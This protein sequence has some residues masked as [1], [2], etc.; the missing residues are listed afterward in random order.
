MIGQ[1]RLYLVAPSAFISHRIPTSMV[2]LAEVILPIHAYFKCNCRKEASQTNFAIF[3]A[4][5]SFSVE[6]RAVR[7]GGLSRL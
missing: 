7:Y 2:E 3:D 4:S 6:I 1:P 5:V